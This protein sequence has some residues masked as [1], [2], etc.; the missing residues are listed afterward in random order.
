MKGTN[1]EVNIEHDSFVV[2]IDDFFSRRH[3]SWIDDCS[4]Q[5]SD[6]IQGLFEHYINEGVVS[7]NAV[8]QENV[9]G[10]TN[11][12]ATQ[13]IFVQGQSEI[14]NDGRLNEG[15]IVVRILPSNC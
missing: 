7:G 11:A 1:L 12:L 8:V 2:R 5:P 9:A 13:S 15:E 14:R 4:S 3:I 6:S 10:Y